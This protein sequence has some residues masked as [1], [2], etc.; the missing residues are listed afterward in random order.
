MNDDCAGAKRYSTN[1]EELVHVESHVEIGESWVQ[2]LELDIMDVFSDQTRNFRGRI[3][4]DIEKGDDIRP[5]GEVLQD[6]DF[7]L[8]LLLLDGLENLY[9]TL[10]LGDDI[11]ALKDLVNVRGVRR[12]EKGRR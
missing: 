5:T 7:S 10:L 12:M 8:D 11:N 1:L 9:D 4:N 3:A 2:N 6:L